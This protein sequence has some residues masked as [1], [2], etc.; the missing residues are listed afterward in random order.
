[1]FLRIC[2]VPDESVVLNAIGY[3][4]IGQW[5]YFPPHVRRGGGKASRTA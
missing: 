5:R 2:A 1:M 4:G 3:G